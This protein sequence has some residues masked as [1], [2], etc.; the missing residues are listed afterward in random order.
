MVGRVAESCYF[1]LLYCLAFVSNLLVSMRSIQNILAFRI[2]SNKT[3]ANRC[4]TLIFLLSSS[5]FSFRLVFFFNFWRNYAANLNNT[6]LESHNVTLIRL[7]LYWYII[8]SL[9]WDKILSILIHIYAVLY[10]LCAL[11][12]TII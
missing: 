8:G 10:V 1:L 7:T 4:Q 11:H 6:A 3:Q 2:C 5:F 9:L 12:Y